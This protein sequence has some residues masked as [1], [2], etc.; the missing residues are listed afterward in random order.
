MCEAREV[1]CSVVVVVVA[2]DIEKEREREKRVRQGNLFM[3]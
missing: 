2:M 3:E 1:Y